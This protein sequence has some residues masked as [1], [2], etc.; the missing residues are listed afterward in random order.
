M[1][2]LMRI[3][4]TGIAAAQ[5]CEERGFDSILGQKTNSCI[6][7]CRQFVF[8]AYN[9]SGLSKLNYKIIVHLKAKFPSISVFVTVCN[10]S[11]VTDDVRLSSDVR[12]FDAK[13]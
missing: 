6:E 4:Q 3:V 12:S 8:F 1:H 7:C 9:G 2:D 11:L 5:L 13:H 10:R